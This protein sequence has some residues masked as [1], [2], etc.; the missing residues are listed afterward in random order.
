[1]S[2]MQWLRDSVTG[3]GLWESIG[4]NS[5]T[6]FGKKTRSLTT[7]FTESSDAQVADENNTIHSGAIK[8]PSDKESILLD[9]SEI[10]RQIEN[11]LDKYDLKRFEH[12]KSFRH[13]WSQAQIE[14]SNRAANEQSAAHKHSES[15][16][17]VLR[18]D[19]GGEDIR[20]L[21]E[22]VHICGKSY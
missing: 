22:S 5:V 1:M 3:A 17:A 10:V 15:A 4:M 18:D 9:V 21:L 14:S 20:M 12:V 7:N 8:C 11:T 16:T 13:L 2:L 19:T 6:S